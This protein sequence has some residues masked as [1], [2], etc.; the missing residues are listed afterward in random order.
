VGRV[1]V[2][3]VDTHVLVWWT[4]AY[5]KLSLV[6]REA[7]EKTEVVAVSAITGWEVGILASRRR[8]EIEGDALWWMRNLAAA[9]NLRILPI[10]LDIGVSR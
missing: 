9:Q 5:D 7:L 1:E 10:T 6:A 3:V 2:I 4:N 8:I